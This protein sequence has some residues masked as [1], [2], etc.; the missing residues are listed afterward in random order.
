MEENDLKK[1]LN[2]FHDHFRA[3]HPNEKYFVII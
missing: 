2:D 1:E 3:E